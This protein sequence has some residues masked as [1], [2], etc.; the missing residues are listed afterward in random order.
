MSV[1]V[2]GDIHGGQ[3]IQFSN[4]HLKSK[5]ITIK[6]DDYL[7]ILGDFGLP[8]DTPNGEITAADKYWLKWLAQKP[9]TVLWIDGNH[10]NFSYWEG[11]PIT[12][13]HGGKVQ[14]HPL[15][16]N[17][18][19][20]MRGEVYEIE[21]KTYFAFGGASSSDK[22]YR[23]AH[24]YGWW[25]Q[26]NASD[27]EMRNAIKNLNAHGNKVDYVL[28]HTPPKSLLNALEWRTLEWRT[29]LNIAESDPT[30][31]FL[32]KI[33]KNSHYDSD[34][35]YGAWFCGHLHEDWSFPMQKLAILYHTVADVCDIEERLNKQRFEVAAKR[36]QASKAYFPQ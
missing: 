33:M 29:P 16:K 22:G 6:K 34:I 7:I 4:R 3:D 8:F 32:S 9:Y 12:Q 11:Q 26:E 27:A 14:V 1:Y 5:H 17:V 18:I 24:G 13:W 10:E 30:A 28:T 31:D 2:T 25:A 15:A 20:L 19:H 23:L 21:G 36:F 35:E